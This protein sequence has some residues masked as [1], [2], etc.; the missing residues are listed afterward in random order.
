MSISILGDSGV[1]NQPTRAGSLEADL[2][3]PMMLDC[4][5]FVSL[6]F[7]TLRVM[8]RRSFRRPKLP[9]PALSSNFSNAIKKAMNWMTSNKFQDYDYIIAT[10]S[11]GEQPK[12][13]DAGAPASCSISSRTRLCSSGS[14]AASPGESSVDSSLGISMETVSSTTS[15]GVPSR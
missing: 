7:D 3:G 6:D 5:I 12:P 10:R 11:G 13:Q 15:G 2:R 8:A 14:R 4:S 9:S 1:V